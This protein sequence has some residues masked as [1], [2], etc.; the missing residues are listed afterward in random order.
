[1]EML[2]IFL[3]PTPRLLLQV[4][5]HEERWARCWNTLRETVTIF[6]LYFWL[7]VPLLTRHADRVISNQL[8]KPPGLTQHFFD[9]TLGKKISK[10]YRNVI[11]VGK[12]IIHHFGVLIALIIRQ[13]ATLQLVQDEVFGD[14]RIRILE[15][16]GALSALLP[17]SR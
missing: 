2:P 8:S 4:S 17:V 7:F 16:N 1:M 3:N 6:V 12:G 9:L 13:M 15:L 14:L 11:T 5:V 10:K